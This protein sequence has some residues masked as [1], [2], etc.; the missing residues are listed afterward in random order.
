LAGTLPSFSKDRCPEAVGETYPTRAIGL[1]AAAA[2]LEDHPRLASPTTRMDGQ[3]L[4][5]SMVA[6]RPAQIQLAAQT[7]LRSCVDHL[8]LATI[9]YG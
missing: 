4:D 6:E 8:C 5:V 1:G 3:Y 7:P 9:S 2:T